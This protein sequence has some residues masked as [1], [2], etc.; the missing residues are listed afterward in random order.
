MQC[1][2]KNT[3]NTVFGAD[4]AGVPPLETMKTLGF[5]PIR[6]CR[7]R[8]ASAAEASKPWPRPVFIKK[9]HVFVVSLETLKTL[10]FALKKN[11]LSEFLRIHTF[12]KTEI[13]EKNAKLSSDKK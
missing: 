11:S 4:W 8:L 9:S 1:C 3:E 2:C 13:S 12:K 7:G 10:G 6:L 5:G